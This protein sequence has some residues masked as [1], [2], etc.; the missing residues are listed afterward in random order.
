VPDA[1]V[2][3]LLGRL[4]NVKHLVL[5]DCGL[6]RGE[7]REGAWAALAKACALAGVTKARER[8][9]RLE[10]WLDTLG[11][12]LPKIKQKPRKKKKGRSGL[13]T[14]NVSLRKKDSDPS[15]V[16]PTLEIPMEE[17]R[18][19]RILPPLPTLQS[20]CTT[21]YMTDEEDRREQI[22]TEWARGW[23]EG[24]AQLARKWKMLYQSSQHGYRIVENSEDVD[25]NVNPEQAEE[26]FNGLEDIDLEENMW[27]F[28]L[29]DLVKTPILCVVGP[30]DIRQHEEGC[31]HRVSSAYWNA[32]L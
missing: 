16:P 14:A 20:L 7:F 4:T 23:A 9:K 15:I 6:I 17:A 31:G 5:D 26:G 22:Q 30:A 1:D 24:V 25:M 19:T 28:D 29:L 3:G 21:I 18:K 32:R 8:E 2:D 11:G 12:V 13:A 27:K 10:I